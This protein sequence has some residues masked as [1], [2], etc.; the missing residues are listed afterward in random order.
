MTNKLS[1]VEFFNEIGRLLPV[2]VK[3]KRSGIWQLDTTCRIENHS[4]G[5]VAGAAAVAMEL[6]RS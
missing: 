3:G 4:T 6:S 1:D 2:W 5:D